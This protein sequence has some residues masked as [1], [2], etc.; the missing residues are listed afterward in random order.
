[1]AGKT[2]R[3]TP[4]MQGYAKEMDQFP[5]YKVRPASLSRVFEYLEGSWSERQL[6]NRG[7]CVRLLEVRLS[8]YFSLPPEAVVVAGNATLAIQGAIQTCEELDQPWL[9]PSWTFPATYLAVHHSGKPYEIVD[10][11]THGWIPQALGDA[12]LVEVWPFGSGEPE[13]S[14]TGSGY[15]LIDAAASFDALRGI[16]DRLNSK[17]AIVLSLHATK[18]LAGGEG[19][20]F[21]STNMEWVSQF[22]DWINFGF[23]NDSRALRLAGTNA[24]MSEGDAAIALAALDE[25]DETR[26]DWV[27]LSRELKPF[28]KDLGFNIPRVF[29]ESWATNYLIIETSQ[30]AQDIVVLQDLGIESR[31]WWV[32]A[33]HGLQHELRFRKG[34]RFENSNRLFETWLGLPFF[35]SMDTKLWKERISEFA[36]LRRE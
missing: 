27:A 36:R 19:G 8:E 31:R 32:P 15:R 13:R 6:T 24:K 35:L 17:S 1:M 20:V 14:S 34:E 25:W 5:I 33:N 3:A 28:L 30:L 12:P 9:V 21:L 11:D 7:P 10:V 4:L 16:G 23:S 29:K 18:A 22:R 26:L 2:H